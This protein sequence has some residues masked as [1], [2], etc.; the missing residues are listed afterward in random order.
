MTFNKE[1]MQNALRRI[2]ELQNDMIQKSKL[3]DG[4]DEYVKQKMILFNE[5]EKVREKLKHI[6]MQEQNLT[7]NFLVSH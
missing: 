3:V 1:F 2:D 5:D 6:R 7:E 4:A